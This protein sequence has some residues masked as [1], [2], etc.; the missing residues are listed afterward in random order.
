MTSLLPAEAQELFR[1]KEVTP[2]FGSAVPDFH[3]L[4]PLPREGYCIDLTTREARTFAEA[5]DRS[6]FEAQL[7]HKQLRFDY[8]VPG[9]RISIPFMPYL[10]HG[11]VASLL[12]G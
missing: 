1:S 5:L 4:T 11:E 2:L 7:S 3:A 6:G 12:G 10:P 9:R 8:A